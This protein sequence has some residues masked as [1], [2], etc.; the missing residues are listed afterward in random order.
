ML[1][2]HEAEHGFLT[3]WHEV[4]NYILFVDFYIL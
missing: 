1:K 4:H 3:L 2:F